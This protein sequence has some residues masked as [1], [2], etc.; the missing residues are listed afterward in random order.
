[1]NKHISDRVIPHTGLCIAVWDIVS[2]ADDKLV[3]HAGTASCDAV[4]RALV[5]APFVGE[6]IPTRIGPSTDAGV[7]AYLRFFNI[8]WVPSAALPVPCAFD[9]ADKVWAWT[10]KVD[11][12]GKE[13]GE[14]EEGEGE[15]LR[16]YMDGGN[17]S[18]VRV[19]A[20]EYD[21]QVATRGGVDDN[22]SGSDVK[23]SSGYSM[24]IKAAMYDEVSEDNQGLGD[25][26]WWYE[27]GD[28]DEEEEY[29]NNDNE[30]D[31]GGNE[32][33]QGEEEGEGEGEGEGWDAG[34]GE[35]VAGDEFVHD[36]GGETA[37]DAEVPD[38]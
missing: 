22:G 36:E 20:V 2:L 17:E 35:V 10:P 18:V 25:P 21:E 31:D 12:D 34:A 24:V 8:V 30:V 27:E 38:E 5:F 15:G 28:G 16:N 3:R 23:K 9:E 11:D 13:E 29:N 32:Y 14:G 37:V 1:M 19:T 7:L 33:A 6:V 26:A 4:F